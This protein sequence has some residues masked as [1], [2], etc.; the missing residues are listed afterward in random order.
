MSPKAI[1]V[2]W[3]VLG[4]ALALVC[5]CSGGSTGGGATSTSAATV[6]P[7]ASV[8]TESFWGEVPAQSSP[9]KAIPP[10]GTGELQIVLHDAP[11]PAVSEVF[12]TFDEVSVHSDASGWLVLS[13]ETQTLDLLALQNGVVDE[14]G[15]GNLPAGNYSQIRLH[16]VSAE[17]GLPSGAREPLTIPSGSQS[18]IKIVHGFAVPDQG[19]VVLTLD[20]D[21]G[22]HLTHSKGQGWKLRPTLVVESEVVTEVCGDVVEFPDPNLE[23][24]VRE[25][26]NKPTGPISAAEAASLTGWLS[27]PSRQIQDL[28]GIQC[29]TGITFLYADNNQISDL[30]PLRDHPSL[31]RVALSLNPVGDLSPL[32]SMPHLTQLSMRGNGL[33]DSDMAPF[34]A[35][36]QLFGLDLGGN[37]LTTIAFTSGMT[38]MLRFDFDS[39]QVTE[40]SALANMPN[41]LRV[42]MSRNPITSGAPLAGATRLNYLDASVTQITDIGFLATIPSLTRIGLN[43]VQ[44]QGGDLSPLATSAP[45]LNTLAIGSTG[46]SDLSPLAAATNM[47]FLNVGGNQIS[48]LSPLSGMTKLRWVFM[49]H[50]LI[51]DLSPLQG[52]TDLYYVY[53]TYNQIQSVEPLRGLTALRDLFLS[54][55]Q[56][57]DPAP[58]LDP[59]ALQAVYIHANPIPDPCNDATLN[60]LI[61]RGV[62]V[63]SDCQ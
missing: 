23:A 33:T 15:L 2:R 18:G 62:T 41:L 28:S 55:N 13:T 63:F 44:I 25:A 47:L 51:T 8:P 17:V 36:T 27:A 16:V 59:P 22:A 11:T 52:K 37:Q 1:V 6:P 31:N 56:I 34:A 39:N 9:P 3:G 21:V 40:V 60:T 12:V 58:L 29:L 35:A 53:A 49:P 5:G 30:E 42:V 61:G 46:V 24:V 43:L 14:L 45:V 57:S 50:N 7:A 10:A 20:W 32:L 48:D 19:R 26:L 54:N 4:V 38:S